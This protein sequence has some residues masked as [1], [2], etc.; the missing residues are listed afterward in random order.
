MKF[1]RKPYTRNFITHSDLM[2]GGTIEAKMTSEPNTKRGIKAEDRP[3][4]LSNE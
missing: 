2:K 3:Y 4:S 1:N